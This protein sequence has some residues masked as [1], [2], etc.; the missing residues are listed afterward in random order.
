MPYQVVGHSGSQPW[1]AA[2]SSSSPVSHPEVVETRKRGAG[3]QGNQVTSRTFHSSPP[4]VADDVPAGESMYQDLVDA[5]RRKAEK[6][7]AP[8]GEEIKQQRI[9]ERPMDAVAFENAMES[10]EKAEKGALSTYHR[11]SGSCH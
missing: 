8:K 9:S 7:V 5:E 1:V 2:S 4:I 10:L 3:D 6:R 11:T